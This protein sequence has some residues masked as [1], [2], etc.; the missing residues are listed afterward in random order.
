MSTFSLDISKW[1]AKAQ[2]NADQVV[3]EVSAEVFNRVIERTPY[4]TGRAKGGWQAGINE[5]VHGETG[6]KDKNGGTTKANMR[7]VVAN[8]KA[9]DIVTLS[10]TQSRTLMIWNTALPLSHLARWSRH[11]SSMRRQF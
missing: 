10:K 3:R 4:Q 11:R 5:T 9:G 2:G 1:V 8:A 7:A 6:I